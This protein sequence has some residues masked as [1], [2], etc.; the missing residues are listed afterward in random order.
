[1]DTSGTPKTLR[2]HQQDTFLLR[3]EGTVAALKEGAGGRREVALDQTAF[4]VESGGQP[5]DSGSLAG[6]PVAGLSLVDG[7]VW[8]LLG[9]PAEGLSKEF[10]VTD[11]C[12]TD[13][14]TAFVRSGRD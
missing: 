9:A 2:L 3:F 4:Y 12:S 11:G 14:R 10:I 1:M 5:A 13:G 8:H 6:W 7:V